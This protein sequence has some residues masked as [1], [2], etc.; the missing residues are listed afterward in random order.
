M[1]V[2]IQEPWIETITT[3]EREF[4]LGDSGSYYSFECNE[5]GHLIKPNEGALRNFRKCRNGTYDVCDNGIQTHER[6]Y[7]HRA[8]IKCKRCDEGEICLANFTN[9]CYECGADYNTAGSLLRDRRCWGEE[10]GEHW[11]ECI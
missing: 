9:T 7:R 1:T 10:T 4:Q 6:T 8:I 11:T 3:H 5:Q 2:Y